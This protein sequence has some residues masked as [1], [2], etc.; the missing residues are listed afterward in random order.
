MKKLLIGLLFSFPAWASFT[1]PPTPHPVNDYANVLT[2]EEMERTASKIVSIK[3]DLGIQVGVLIVSSLDGTSIEEAS[4]QVMDKWKLGSK[5]NDD[6]VLLMLAINDRK[7]RIEVGRGLEGALTDA[8][9]KRILVEMRSF[10]KV[11]Q[12]GGAV[13]N[14]L[15]NIYQQ[16]RDHKND[17]MTRPVS[18]SSGINWSAFFLWL[19]ILLPLGIGMMVYFSRKAAKKAAEDAAKASKRSQENKDILAR[20]S[21]MSYASRRSES[22]SPPAKSKATKKSSNSYTPIIAPV[23]IDNS[24]SD[25]D[26][27]SR[28]SSSSSSYSSSSDSY[29][30]SDWSGGGGGSSGG[31]SSDSW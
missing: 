11:Q 31:G 16:I 8:Q 12:Y 17:M 18:A 14:G 26:S 30:S 21:A 15:A 29:S 28:S 10:L 23:Y 20:L 19:A 2:A 6:G 13:N 24:S 22:Y 5:T 3:K 1:V 27:S 25:D 7:S 9:S 4:V